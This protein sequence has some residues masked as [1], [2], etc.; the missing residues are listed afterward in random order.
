MVIHM[1]TATVL[2]GGSDTRL[3]KYQTSVPVCHKGDNNSTILHFVFPDGY[4]DYLKKIKFNVKIYRIVYSGLQGLAA[5]GQAY[6]TGDLTVTPEEWER[7]ENGYTYT[8]DVVLDPD[9]YISGILADPDL[10]ISPRKDEGNHNPKIYTDANIRATN[11]EP[12]EGT[13]SI[14]LFAKRLPKDTVVLDCWVFGKMYEQGTPEL[15]LVDAEYDLDDNNDVAI[16]AEL[17]SAGNTNTKFKLEIHS[18]S[19]SY[20]ETSN[21]LKLPIIGM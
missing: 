6:Q 8:G 21:Q 3:L 19:N 16:P 17:T 5:N 7:V 20:V 9:Q 15:K 10:I 2:Y 14:T 11:I 13:Y 4:T 1:P 12:T 18:A